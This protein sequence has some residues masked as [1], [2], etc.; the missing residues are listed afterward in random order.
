MFL[1]KQL[2]LL[3]LTKIYITTTTLKI[4]EFRPPLQNPLIIKNSEIYNTEKIFKEKISIFGKNLDFIKIEEKIY[5]EN[6]RLIKF[7]KI[8]NLKIRENLEKNFYKEF[9][10]NNFLT[11]IS[12]KKKFCKKINFEF[13]EK[14]D[15]EKKDYKDFLFYKDIYNKEIRKKEDF[16]VLFLN[17]NNFENFEN[18]QNFIKKNLYFE[19]EEEKIF[20]HN[21]C[22][23]ENF[24]K[25]ENSQNSQ[26][27][28]KLKI[29]II[30]NVTNLNLQK[31][32]SINHQILKNL[33]SSQFIIFLE[34]LIEFHFFTTNQNFS[35]KKKNFITKKKKFIK[36][37]LNP[38]KSIEDNNDF[39][40]QQIREIIE[41]KF[42]IR[43]K[44]S[45]INFLR[46]YFLKLFYKFQDLKLDFKNFFIFQN[47]RNFLRN[48]FFDEKNFD[49]VFES[50]REEKDY[51]VDGCFDDTSDCGFMDSLLDQRSHSFYVDEGFS[52]IGIWVLFIFL[53]YFI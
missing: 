26:K 2:L 38:I 28:E 31:F 3:F 13:F 9:L 44:L 24:Q 23:Y 51:F 33:D 14:I 43:I 46:I 42:K 6:Y 15:N 35:T 22:F 1:I 37:F 29:K 21:F 41:K 16:V 47:F 45:Q 10:E 32:S 53:L 48:I 18:F 11:K 49:L 34:N 19:K 20:F 50:F 17:K 27:I 8:L 39:L 5:Y 25:I 4:S 36:F 40:V 30:F 52:I 12:K 7:P